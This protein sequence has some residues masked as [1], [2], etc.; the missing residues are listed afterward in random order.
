MDSKLRSISIGLS[1]VVILLVSMLVLYMNGDF[2]KG[3]ETFGN[4]GNGSQISAET[5]NSNGGNAG[6]FGGDGSGSAGVAGSTVGE[7]TGRPGGQIGTDLEGFL[8][9]DNFFDREQD[10]ES[11][12]EV[13]RLS[14]I[15]TS[16]EKDLRIQIVDMEGEPVPG[17][18]F[19]VE[20]DGLGEYK[21]LD[22]DGIVYI[23]GLKAGD[24]HVKLLPLEGFQVPSNSTRVR[25]KEQVEYVAIDDIAL[26]ILT[27][28]DIDAMAEDTRRTEV[29]EDVDQTEIKEFHRPMSGTAMGI[30]V[31]KWNGDIDWDKVKA[32]GVEFAIIRVGY[33]GSV[34]G[35]LV[36]DPKLEENLK[37]ATAAGLQ[38]GVY[39]VS[40]AVNEVEAVEEASAVMELVK[41]YELA[42][43]IF[44]DS[45]SAG[46]DGRGD[47]ISPEI[48][49]L[50]CEAFCRTL[51]NAGYEAGIYASTWWYNNKLIV[52]R[53]DDDYFIWL[54]EYKSEPTYDGYYQMWQYT[55]KGSIDG[56]EGNVDINVRYY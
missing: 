26:L 1:L 34:T 20:V 27:E 11:S 29:S 33:R 28:A 3:R 31:S 24:Y 22:K 25:V 8:Q 53:L 40:Q 10:A 35:A 6:A 55:S 14:L 18:G 4:G 23:A 39:F 7:E 2:G 46:G 5:G 51:E 41:D 16:V 36:V 52:D 50:T 42:Y 19:Y 37:G 32:A 47:V 56:I 9:D 49:T 12:A 44:L 54:A 43:P 30:D 38:L 17:Y 21:D 13:S 15:V 45:E 48:R